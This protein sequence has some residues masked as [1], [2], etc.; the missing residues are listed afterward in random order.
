MHMPQAYF[1]ITLACQLRESWLLVDLCIARHCSPQ[2]TQQLVEEANEML[3]YIQDIFD[4]L[5][6]SVY[7][8]FADALLSVFYGPVVIQSLL[9]LK[10]KLQ[11]HSSLYILTQTLINVPSFAKQVR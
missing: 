7:Q 8:V 10:P 9:A 6:E 5:A 4:H 3:F 2:E 1:F 11:I